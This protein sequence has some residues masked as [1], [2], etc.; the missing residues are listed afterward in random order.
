MVPL[1]GSH[2]TLYSHSPVPPPLV[3]RSNW[4][5]QVADYYNYKY[6]HK[7]VDMFD[8]HTAFEALSGDV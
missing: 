4:F 3:L 1:H 6:T 8:P 2:F 7:C 5:V